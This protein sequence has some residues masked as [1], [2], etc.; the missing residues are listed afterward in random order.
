MIECHCVYT[1]HPMQQ[2]HLCKVSCCGGKGSCCS[3][4]LPAS[5][6][7]WGLSNPGLGFRVHL[8]AGFRL[9]LSAG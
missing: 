8:S 9:R 1:V 6:I 2:P 3:S 7:L 5:D 4:L